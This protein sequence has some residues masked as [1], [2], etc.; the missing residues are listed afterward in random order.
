MR[1][2]WWHILLVVS[3]VQFIV[4]GS[5]LWVWMCG[6]DPRDVLLGCIAIDLLVVGI[7]M[8]AFVVINAGDATTD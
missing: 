1:L 3:A 2:K 6:S 4:G 8:V 5:G 7:G